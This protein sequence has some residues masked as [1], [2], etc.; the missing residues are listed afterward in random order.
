MP[1]GFY[2]RY[3][4][5]GVTDGIAYYLIPAADVGGL[6]MP[7]SCY[8]KQLTAFEHQTTELPPQQRTPAIIWERHLIK[9]R[10]GKNPES[11]S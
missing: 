9:Q 7:D 11:C 10:E 3:S 5:E 1:Q 4:R 6:P 2:V 8:A